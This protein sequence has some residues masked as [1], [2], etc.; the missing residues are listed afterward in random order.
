MTG[1]VVCS[2]KIFNPSRLSD[3]MPITH[4]FTY[5]PG[6]SESREKYGLTKKLYLKSMP[7]I[8]RVPDPSR[9][10]AFPTQGFSQ[11]SI[12]KILCRSTIVGKQSKNIY[13]LFHFFKNEG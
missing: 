5:C 11:I 3:A 8:P 4:G 12:G 13:P 1:L 2:G 9:V 6:H 7:Q 10:L